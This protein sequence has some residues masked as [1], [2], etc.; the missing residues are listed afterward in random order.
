METRR[1][2]SILICFMSTQKIMNSS[3]TE[4]VISL[5]R[6]GARLPYVPTFGNYDFYDEKALIDDSD[7]TP[8][9]MR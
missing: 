7:L 6:H 3:N 8:V 5:F 4:L 2:L 9:G 1:L